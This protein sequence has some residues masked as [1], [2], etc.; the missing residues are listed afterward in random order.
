MISFVYDPPCQKL[1]NFT[2]VF[3]ASKRP[4]LELEGGAWTNKKK[5]SCCNIE[6]AACGAVFVSDKKRI[7]GLDF[8]IMA[9]RL[10]IVE[11]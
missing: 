7:L 11:G 1:V 2:S 5:S 4:P 8:L 3:Q 9:R 6:H 10:R